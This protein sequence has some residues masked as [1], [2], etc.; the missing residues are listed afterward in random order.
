VSNERGLGLSGDNR[1]LLAGLNDGTVRTWEV[2]TSRE[3]LR[4]EGTPSEAVISVVYSKDDRYVLS[5]ASDNIVRL[6]NAQT[7]EQIQSFSGH[8]GEIHGLAVSPDGRYV[9]SSSLDNTTRVWEAAT[10]EEIQRIE[11][12][13]DAIDI[14]PDGHYVVIN[15][16]LWDWQSGK[17]VQYAMPHLCWG[18]SFSWDGNA[19]ARACTDG[20]VYLWAVKPTTIERLVPLPGSNMP[21]MGISP[22]GK[23]LVVD[24][25]NEIVLIDFTSGK[26]T[27]RLPAPEQIWNVGFSRD[28]QTI[29]ATGLGGG[30]FT[31][32]TRT[33]EIRSQLKLDQGGVGEVSPDGKQ[34]IL[35]DYGTLNNYWIDAMTGKTLCTFPGPYLQEAIFSPDG[36]RV[37]LGGGEEG[38]NVVRIFSLPDCQNIQNL[39]ASEGNIVV[40]EAFSPDGRYLAASLASAQNPLI[41]WDT[42]TG[43]IVHEIQTLPSYSWDLTYSPDGKYLA[44]TSDNTYIW[45]TSSWNVVR[46]IVGSWMGVVFSPDGKWVM[47]TSLEQLGLK[48]S[49]FDLA[50]LKDAVCQGL[51]RE[52]TEAERVRFGIT[53]SDPACP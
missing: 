33:W 11:K 35:W 14:S 5:A 47:T 43:E 17:T 37:A 18:A 49:Y 38:K 1:F 48:W 44:A 52:L 24:I 21:Y 41:I 7:G 9:A 16:L 4:M 39:D 36:K 25:V 32:D 51:W 45:D 8:I 29:Y 22:D 12:A 42:Q 20:N 15:E 27:A 2:S 40:S 28:G 26:E 23:T 30:Y 46:R 13:A 34:W 53:T 10:G 50:E 6:W 3:A 19:I 31:W